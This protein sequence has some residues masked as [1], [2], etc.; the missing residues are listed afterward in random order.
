[1]ATP[2]SDVYSVG[3]VAYEML[4]GELPFAAETPVGVAMRHVHDPAPRPT[5][6]APSLPPQI[7]PIILRALAKE[8]TRRW[9]SAGASARALREWR[10][11]APPGPVAP[12][13]R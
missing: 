2:A 4:T 5:Q 6:V 12:A 3:V 8:P 11:M 13:P 1:M 10:N 7:D 9:G